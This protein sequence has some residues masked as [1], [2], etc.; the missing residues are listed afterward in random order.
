MPPCA[1]LAPPGRGRSRSDPASVSPSPPMRF[2]PLP[3]QSSRTALILDRFSE[4][5]TIHYCSNDSLVET[6]AAMGRSFFDFVMPRHE[7]LVR[8]WIDVVKGW[9]VNERG[10]PSDGGFGFGKFALCVRGRDS[11]YVPLTKSRPS[12][13]QRSNIS[14]TL[15]SLPCSTASR[16]TH[17]HREL[18]G[19]H[20]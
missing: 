17:L 14:I 10:Q 15:S 11:R 7:D 19:V 5:C 9:G 20:P 12:L 1:I 6:S 3:E 13:Y 16:S 4:R 2:S 18:A 8:N